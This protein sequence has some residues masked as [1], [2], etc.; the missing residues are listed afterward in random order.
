MRR[1][2]ALLVAAACGKSMPP[3]N[4]GYDQIDVEPANATLMVALGG[5]ATQ[6]YTVYGIS[7][8]K[9]VDITADCALSIDTA[10]GTF[11]AQ[12]LTV[13]PH[14]GKTS[15][16]ATCGKQ[17][18]STGVIIQLVSQIVVG[19]AQP[20]LFG[21][22]TTGSDPSR[23]PVFQYP[24]DQAVSP[25]NIPPIEIQW[26]AAGNDQFHIVLTTTFA[27]IDVYTTDVQATLAQTD[28]DA[29][30]N[31]A[32][33]DRMTFAIEA[34][35]A[36]QPQQKFV[37]TPISI[38][39][40]RDSIDKTAI[41]WWASSQ[42]TLMTQTFG[43]VTAPTIVKNDCT[44]CH[45][46]SRTATRIGYSRCVANDCNQLYAGFM[47]FDSNANQWVESVNANAEAIR[48]SYTT[49]APVGN[50][51]PDDT[52]SLAIVSMIT[53]TLALYDPDTGAPVTSNLDV[54]THGPGAPRSAL[55][56]DWSPDGSHVVFASTPHPSQWIDLSDGAIATMTYN[57]VGGM[58]VFGE[59]Q[60]LQINPI[61]LPGGTY[62]NFFFPS[63]S[64]DGAVIVFD[65]A[66]S[67]W[68]TFTDAA[69][70]GQ[71]LLLADAGGAWGVDLT[72][73]NGGT[74]DHD[75]TWAHWAPV[76][77]SDYYWVVF[78]SE[79]DYGHEV[80]AANTDTDCVHNGVKQ[81]KQIWLA[82]ISKSKLGGGTDPS[83]PPM[84]LPG[85]DP[86]A[87]NIS[88]YWS[89]PNGLQ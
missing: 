10:F 63:Y 68:R 12:T 34:L 21:G 64:P 17:T 3:A 4:T 79:R 85:Q 61:T 71:R 62:T 19:S 13:G 16:T 81:C 11:A 52:R 77:S 18:G 15:V 51:F 80:T 74:G 27:T 83:A 45:S 39:M 35:L 53:G 57:Y 7:G 84:W 48:G 70:A 24:I 59:P 41:Y 73:L 33:G 1:G 54:A 29:L 89:L 5:T 56:A 8:G 78:S 23:T 26:A 75:I 28:W 72:A 30:A 65:A 60:F 36:A 88:P 40:S 38:A 58:H 47:H 49:F 76:E 44:S 87:D 55:M 20:G 66:R 67:G 25:L 14:G 31:T 43:T 22:A 46:V 37:G 6:D 42:G 32:A 82:A 50:P 9:M 2:I 86:K 69:S